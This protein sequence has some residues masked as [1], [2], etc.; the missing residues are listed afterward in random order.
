MN[1]LL[2]WLARKLIGNGL[3]QVDDS[4]M[5]GLTLAME[6]EFA[7]LNAQVNGCG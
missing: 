6:E 1:T 3:T 2:R 5:D 7:L 4:L